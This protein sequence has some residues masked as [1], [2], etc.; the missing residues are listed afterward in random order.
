[1]RPLTKNDR[2][3]ALEIA[4]EVQ[5]MPEPVTVIA[6]FT[7]MEDGV[8]LPPLGIQRIDVGPA[9]AFLSAYGRAAPSSFAA[10]PSWRLNH[11]AKAGT[12][13]TGGTVER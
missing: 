6:P 2:A 4:K 9:L 7:P 12:D 10:K 11:G 3:K 8:S 1:M 13:T 5:Q